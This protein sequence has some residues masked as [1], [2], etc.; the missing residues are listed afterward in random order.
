MQF[1]DS[2]SRQSLR[3]FRDLR[4]SLIDKGSYRVVIS[5]QNHLLAKNSYLR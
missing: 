1:E 4:P 5:F 2:H 3:F